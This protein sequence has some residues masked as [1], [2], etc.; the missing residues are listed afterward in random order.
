MENIG[1]N[2]TS[3][4]G[5]LAPRCAVDA[6]VHFQTSDFFFDEFFRLCAAMSGK[7]TIIN[8]WGFQ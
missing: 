3:I 4:L 1:P 6:R 2:E 8:N 5:R 7:I